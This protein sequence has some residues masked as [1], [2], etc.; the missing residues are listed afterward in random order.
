MRSAGHNP[1][2]ASEI[3]GQSPLCGH[4]ASRHSGFDHTSGSIFQGNVMGNDEGGIDCPIDSMK[5][6]AFARGVPRRG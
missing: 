4:G 3:Y 6:H 5:A 2:P 1:P